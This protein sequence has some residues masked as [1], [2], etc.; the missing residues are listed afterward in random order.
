MAG[1]LSCDGIASITAMGRAEWFP[2]SERNM[3]CLGDANM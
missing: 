1:V 2:D 3:M